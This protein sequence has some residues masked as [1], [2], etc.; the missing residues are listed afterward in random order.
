[1]GRSLIKSS[2]LIL[3]II[4]VF[5]VRAAADTI[6]WYHPIPMTKLGMADSI[7]QSVLAGSSNHFIYFTKGSNSLARYNLRGPDGNIYHLSEEFGA[8]GSPKPGNLA[9]LS[10]NQDRVV[11]LD[12]PVGAP[13]TAA[14]A[15]MRYLRFVIP[16]ASIR[17]SIY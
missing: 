16:A 5:P 8:A 4:A 3:M 1:M 17:Q 14:E 12:C 11:F 2:L 7:Y 9:A 6:F 15:I 10:V 13:Q